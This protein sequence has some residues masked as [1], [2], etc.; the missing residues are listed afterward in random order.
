MKKKLLIF[1]LFIGLVFSLIACDNT[2]KLYV[3]NV[4]DYIDMSI[5]KDFEEEY[6]CKVVYTELNSNEEIYQ[7]L[8][9]EKYDIVVI[10]DYMIE[11]MMVEGLI[12]EIDYSK[13][14]NYNYDSLFSE[15][16]ELIEHQCTPY[17]NYFIPYFWGTVGILYNTDCEG[18]EEDI[19]ENGISVLFS[20][21]SYNKGM[22]NS[23]RDALSLALIALGYEEYINVNDEGKLREAMSLIQSVTYRAWGDDNLKS[24]VHSGMLDLA[25]VY[26]GDY[27]DEYYQCEIDDEEI[28]FNYYA[29]D[30]T[31][32]W[33]DG[34]A[35]T[36]NARNEELA[37]KFIDYF[38]IEDIQAQNADYIGYCPLSE[39]VFNILIDEYEYDIDREFFVPYGPNRILY[40]FISNSHY[41]LLNDLLEESKS[42]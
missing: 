10:S 13:L 2:Q 12:K 30:I 37:Y 25:L 26:S 22:Y 36:K 20:N 38:Q 41:N 32:I 18:L 9:N 35:I 39:T 23:S 14:E 3:L 1:S 31:N 15:A 28:N 7:K 29:P 40:R 42:K 21:N 33:V 16:K 19:L 27:L 6:N 4:G 17:K 8:K 34:L 24:M 11:R 5:V